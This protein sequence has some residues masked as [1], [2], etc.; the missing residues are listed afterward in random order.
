MTCP[1]SAMSSDLAPP[2]GAPLLYTS[3][4]PSIY[5]LGPYCRSKCPLILQTTMCIT[6]D[7]IGATDV[8]LSFHAAV[9]RLLR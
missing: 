9:K 8:S 3:F 4:K 5:D 7:W 2:L 6:W 1:C